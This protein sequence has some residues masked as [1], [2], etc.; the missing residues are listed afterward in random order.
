M[1]IYIY[2]FDF[3]GTALL[4]LLSASPRPRSFYYYFSFFNRVLLFL[5][6][7]VSTHLKMSKKEIDGLSDSVLRISSVESINDVAEYPVSRC[8]KQGKE[9]SVD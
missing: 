8:F 2:T 6:I 9:K 7:V 1:Y 3:A 5:W 4:V